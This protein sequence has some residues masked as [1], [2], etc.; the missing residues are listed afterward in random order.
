[1][2]NF[3]KPKLPRLTYCLVSDNGRGNAEIVAMFGVAVLTTVELL[4]KQHPF[5]KSSKLRNFGIVFSQVLH[6]AA[7]DGEVLCLGNEHRWITP[8]VR[9]AYEHG[10][11]IEG[12]PG[13]EA[14]VLKA[15]ERSDDDEIGKDVQAKNKKAWRLEDDYDDEGARIWR[16]W[17]WK[18]EVRRHRLFNKL[19]WSLIHW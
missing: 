4:I 10:I 9:L 1:V 5:S 12:I 17:D 8:M 19:N 13:I 16:H 11:K 15:R 3:P 7:I 6:F 2:P 18:K 14:N